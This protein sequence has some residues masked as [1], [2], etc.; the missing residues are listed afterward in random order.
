[1][2]DWMDGLRFRIAKGEAW[3]EGKV[4]DTDRKINKSDTE[5]RDRRVMR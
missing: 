3:L 4:V 5:A 1:M 2:S